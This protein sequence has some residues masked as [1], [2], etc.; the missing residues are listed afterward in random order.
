MTDNRNNSNATN[1]QQTL[2]LQQ[3]I[4]LALK[5]HTA[6]DLPKAD[7]IYRQ[8]L[9]AEPN[10]PVALHLLG[11]IAHQV[12]KNDIAI[13]FIRRALAHKPDYAEAYNSLGAALKGQGMVDEAIESYHKALAIKPE[14]VEAHCNLGNALTEQGKS[15]DAIARY[16]EALAID[17]ENAEAH[18][19]LGNVFFETGQID[20]AIA[21]C[22]KAVALKPNFA[23]A[24]NNLGN[25]LKEQGKLDEAIARYRES[26]ILNPKFA[27]AHNNLGNV[28]KER[29]ELEDAVLSYHQALTHKPDFAEAHNN[30]GAALMEQG[31]GDEAVLCYHKAVTLKP[32]NAKLHNSLG[33]AHRRQG[34]LEE[35]IASYRK[36]IALKPDFAEAHGNL[37]NVFNEKGQL[38]DAVA[39]CRR[40][41]AIEP[42]WAAAHDNL[43]NVLKE[44]G[45][46]EEAVASYLKALA[47][48]PDYAQ[49][50]NNLGLALQDQGNLD[51]AV[52]SFRKAITIAPHIAEAHNNLGNALKILGH[53]DAAIFSYRQALVLQPNYTKAHS[54]LIFCMGYS[55][56]LT[57]AEILQEAKRWQETH[58]FKGDLPRHGNTPEPDRRL[59]IGLV[60]GDLRHHSVSYFLEAVLSHLDTKKLELYAYSSFVKEDDMTARIKSIVAKW[61][62]ASGRSDSQLAGDITADQIDILVDLSGHTAYNRLPVFSR[63]PA[64]VS[65]TWLGYGGTTGVDAMDYILSDLQVLPEFDTAAFTEKPW[66]LPETWLCFLPPNLNIEVGPPPALA[67][68]NITFGSFNNLTKVSDQTVACWAQVLKAVPNSRLLLKSMQ[69][70]D[71]AVR[72]TTFTRFATE[73]IDRQRLILKGHAS[74]QTDH[75]RSYG[76]IDIALDTFPYAGGAT[77]IEALWMGT[78]VL[79]LR[80]DRFVS[81][82]GASILHNVGLEAWIADTE[83]IYV[84]KAKAFATDLSGLSA[85]GKGLRSQLLQSPVCD[86]PRFAVNLEGAFRGMWKT[87]LEQRK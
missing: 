29:G 71:A 75:L 67:E 53:L 17:P 6:G 13:D 54:N 4:D 56:K 50:H 48:K 66:R 5:Y 52:V 34:A 28:L 78:P 16:R 70:G 25:A 11:V 57:S 44:Q 49:A 82:M 1:G 47:I 24:H 32:N 60:S 27:E 65:V 20:D 18:N 39:S 69:L 14:Y 22:R 79:S 84:E 43:G 23:E 38:D 26:L 62:N 41:V 8:I 51:D 80:G 9:Q 7:N 85:L 72:E 81:H 19:N 77:S 36:A 33:N 86:A 74:E 61:R 64:P 15:N 59:R 2:T 30:L 31:M 10:H 76:N 58:G 87:W 63:K 40:A 12:G 73:G 83:E 45:K 3:A 35:A 21:S 68:G 46:R 42:D 37:G 55:A